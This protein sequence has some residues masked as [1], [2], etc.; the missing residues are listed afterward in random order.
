L[1]PYG[2]RIAFEAAMRNV[3]QAFR[4]LRKNP[5]F[6]FSVLAIL[7]LGI[8]ANT[9]I[10][11]IVNAVLL[12]PLPYSEPDS[13]VAVYHVPPPQS[14][15]G[16][17]TF[18]VSP[19]NYLD[20]REQNTVFDS[21]T[22]IG[23][24]L[25]RISGINRPES[26]TLTVTEA[27]FF[28][29]LGMSPALGRAF[30]DAECKPGH[31]DVVVLSNAFA[32]KE[33]GGAREALDRRLELNGRAFRVIGVM[34]P[35]FELK[36]WFPASN[37][38]VVPVAWTAKEAAVRDDHNYTVIARLRRGVSAGAAQT[39]MNMISER[40]AE[41]HPEEDKG[42]GATVRTLRNDLVGNV[43]PALLA[44]LGAVFFV[45]LIACANTANLVLV[46]T[47]MRRKELAIRAALG[48][49]SSQVLQPVLIETIL[50]ALA[51]GGLGLLLAGSAQS[52]VLSALAKQ[53]PR[54]VDVRLDGT[55]LAFTFAAS[56]ATGLAAGMI[57]GWRLTKVHV[58]EALKLG[59][60]KTDSYSGGRRTR[61][62][63]VAAGVALSLM[64][65]I[66]AGL[67][68]RSLW[69]LQGVDPGF[70]SAHAVTM[71][72]P[73]PQ[74]AQ[75]KGRTRFY[76][77][78]LPQV[79]SLPGVLAAAAVDVLPLGGGGSQQPVVIEGRPAEVFALQPT[80]AVRVATPG[81][82]ETMHIPLMNGREFN[83]EDTVSQRDPSPVVI[84]ESMARQFWPDKNPIGRRLRLSFSPEIQREVIGVTG[85][86]KERGLDV[87]EPVAMLYV[88]LPQNESGNVSLVVRGSGDTAALV[89]AITRVLQGI[90]PQ[91]TVRR[92]TTLDEMVA[93]ALSQHRFNMFLFVALAAVAFLLAAVGIYSVLTYNVRSRTPEIS[94][95]MALGARI[96]DIL[97]LVLTDGMKPALAG[98]VLG[99]FAALFLTGLLSKMIY[100]ITPTDPVTFVFVGLLLTTVAAAACLLPA[101]RATRLD[102]IQSLRNE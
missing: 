75:E 39:Q 93:T 29:V 20:W 37:D 4:L 42:W 71:R 80:V 85:D 23:A 70:V 6:T 7:A 62:A 78:F 94:I 18:A 41:T 25:V 1:P 11:G 91:A 86:V 101:W 35:E 54:A 84:S 60:G 83:E 38:G 44:L 81:Y 47:V 56:V 88:P 57:A 77:D 66:G 34:P 36:S 14:F 40:L 67:M 31:D 2:I 82:F 28:R 63:L 89:P 74:P 92:P 76:T 30:T 8:G 19:A 46:R 95:R 65:L 51:G 64:L 21:M 26:M 97:R 43:E 98:M 99:G 13:I 32:A 15:P 58:N 53:L 79:R 12:K 3:V 68:V 69:A 45:L 72:V 59:L 10:F 33:Y 9:A 61:D 73:I 16:M 5:G 24:R 22:V 96:G 87:L 102:P 90:D 50:L 48:A 27:G 49:S 52:L 100:G 55:V 17:K